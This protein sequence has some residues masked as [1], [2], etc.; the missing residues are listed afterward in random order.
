MHRI[1]DDVKVNMTGKAELSSKNQRGHSYLKLV[2]IK[3][4]GFIGDARGRLVDNSNNPENSV[5]GMLPVTLW[6]KFN[7]MPKKQCFLIDKL[8]KHISI[9]INIKFR[10][11]AF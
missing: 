3:F 7:N 5:F 6:S 2:E 4:K 1:P 8:S 10:K 11:I 9:L